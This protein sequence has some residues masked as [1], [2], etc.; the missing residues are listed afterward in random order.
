[1]HGIQPSNPGSLINMPSSFNKTFFLKTDLLDQARETTLK[2]V[3]FFSAVQNELTRAIIVM[4]NGVAHF[5]GQQ[6]RANQ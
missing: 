3:L 1:M 6:E 4:S 2:D 5:T